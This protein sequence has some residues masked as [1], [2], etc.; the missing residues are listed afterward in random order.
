MKNNTRYQ[1]RKNQNKSLIL[2]GGGLV[3]L[4]V[5][6]LVLKA[7]GVIGKSNAIEVET[8]VVEK[9]T[10]KETVSASGRLKPEKEVKISPD[11]SGEIIELTVKA[12]DR[13]KKGDLLV[14]I[15]PDEYQST[16]EDAL[17]AYKSAQAGLETAKTNLRQAEAILKQNEKIY[18]RYV[19]LKE[20]N[21]VSES[22]FERIETEYLTQ[23][24]NFEN[25]RK[26]VENAKYSIIRA[27]ASVDKARENLRKT[28]I[29]SPMDGI[30]TLLNNE[31]GERVVGTGLMQ[32]TVI[33]QIADLSVM[34]VVVDVNEHDIIKIHPG[35]TAKIEVDAFPDRE[36]RGT[37]IEM[38]HSSRQ[39]SNLT[40]QITTYE[41][42]IRIDEDSYRDLTDSSAVVNSPFRPGMSAMVDIVT[43]IRKDVPAVPV[44]AVTTRTPDEL[45]DSLQKK[46]ENEESVLVTFVYNNG[47]ALI[48]PVKVGIQDDYFIEIKEGLKVGET[49]ISGPFTTVSK[50]LKNNQLV[51]KTKND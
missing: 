42:K 10:I 45:P 48:R 20:K 22:E 34:D 47:K 37:V 31:K 39:E 27:K 29:Y 17:A 35:D 26:N 43:E 25:A 14:R 50:I 13:V 3:L 38:A 40:E 44:L 18:Q 30:V 51:K 32:G 7:A 12:G 6:L 15:K 8:A 28:S 49:V 21:A 23:K 2:I 11:V 4:I 46:F 16:L 5:I 24:A 33:M 19:Q 1:T 41:V 9:K 36:F